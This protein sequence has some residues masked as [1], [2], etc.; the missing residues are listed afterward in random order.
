[1]IEKWQVGSR[2]R[3]SERVTEWESPQGP[4]NGEK[5]IRGEERKQERLSD[6]GTKISWPIR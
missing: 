2:E 4:R 3:S 6:D 5:E 1:M